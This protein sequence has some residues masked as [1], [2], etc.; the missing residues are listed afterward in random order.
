MSLILIC[1]VLN[2]N[3]ERE[4]TSVERV[5]PSRGLAWVEYGLVGFKVATELRY[6]Y[7]FMELTDKTF[8]V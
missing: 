2:S 3:L 6:I 4:E 8:I 7:F 1:K 5:S